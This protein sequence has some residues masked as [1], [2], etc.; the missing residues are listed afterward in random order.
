MGGTAC[1]YGVIPHWTPSRHPAGNFGT[2]LSQTAHHAGYARTTIAPSYL[3]KLE[4][5]DV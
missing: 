1:V 2:V 3:T 5:T 4:I